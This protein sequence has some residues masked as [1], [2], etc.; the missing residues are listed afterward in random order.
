[1]P[2]ESAGAEPFDAGPGSVVIDC[3]GAVLVIALEQVCLGRWFT[4]TGLSA[5]ER[6]G[7]ARSLEYA[8]SRTNVGGMVWAKTQQM[9][10]RCVFLAES[11]GVKI[12]A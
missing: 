1:M 6:V 9:R 11:R 2:G 7:V 12:D 4:R 5:P 10:D 3:R 8:S